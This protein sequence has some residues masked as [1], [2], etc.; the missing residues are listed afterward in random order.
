MR[1]ATALAV[2][3]DLPR[4]VECQGIAFGV[5]VQRSNVRDGIGRFLDFR[6][7]LSHENGVLPSPVLGG[8]VGGG[9][10][11]RRAGLAQG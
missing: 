4:C 10:Q 1:Q 9:G 2:T 11:F 3:D 7:S 6:R 8:G 5:A